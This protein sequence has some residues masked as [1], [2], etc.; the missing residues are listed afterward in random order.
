MARS[1]RFW[2]S[3]LLFLSLGGCLPNNYLS[4]VAASSGVALISALLSDLYDAVIPPF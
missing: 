2:F 4:S 1:I 3:V